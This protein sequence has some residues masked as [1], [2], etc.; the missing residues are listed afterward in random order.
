MALFY[1]RLTIYL[2]LLVVILLLIPQIKPV[3]AESYTL[4][5]SNSVCTYLNSSGVP[6]FQG[7]SSVGAPVLTSLQPSCMDGKPVVT[8]SWQGSPT[9]GVGWHHYDRFELVNDGGYTIT[10]AQ[11]GDGSGQP[12]GTILSLS[13]PIQLESGY[14]GSA[15]VPDT[16][17]LDSHLI[18]FSTYIPLKPGTRYI[19]SM[20]AQIGFE[21]P[22]QGMQSP[23]SNAMLI[24][25]PVCPQPFQQNNPIASCTGTTPQI[26]LSWQPSTGATGYYVYFTDSAVNKTEGGWLVRGPTTFTI[27]SDAKFIPGHYYG[28][29]IKAFNG[30][31][32]IY[33]NDFTWSQYM[34]GWT[35]YPDCSTPGSFTFNNVSPRCAALNDPVIDVSWNSSPGATSYLVFPQKNPGLYYYPS[36]LTPSWWNSSG[37]Y[38][39]HHVSLYS[40][41][42]GQWDYN[43][44]AVNPNGST[45]IS[46]GSSYHHYGWITEYNCGQ[47]EINLKIDNTELLK[48]IDNGQQI[49]LTYEI[50]NAYFATTSA[51]PSVASLTSLWTNLFP[52]NSPLSNPWSLTGL[53]EVTLFNDQSY[54][55]D[56]YQF[57]LQATN[58]KVPGTPSVTKTVTVNV[59]PQFDPFIQTT[60]GDVHSNQNI[61]VPE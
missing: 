25:T 46:G 56:S 5:C 43:I 15:P 19:Y 20:R 24:T 29:V 41:P 37:G 14:T 54:P 16:S 22:P 6:S 27:P 23:P 48:T 34:Y 60:Q 13:G 17:A 51:N 38:L 42:G 7:S 58:P 31:Y 4:S 49:A 2:L 8:L 39:E 45:W 61:N 12:P 50:H 28:F 55:Y 1:V 26:N 18:P 52:A 47:P 36:G 33:S 53:R 32:E 21:N 30:P 59:L 40:T 3:R 35:Q 57:T 11:P 9:P 44:L 10:I